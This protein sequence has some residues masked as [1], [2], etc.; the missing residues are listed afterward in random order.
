MKIIYT[1]GPYSGKD[2]LDI[3]QNIINAS[4]VAIECWR[5]GWAVICPHKNTSGYETFEGG[6]INWGTW[7]KGDLEIISRCD[8]IVMIQGWEKSKGAR[9]ELDF[10][11]KKGIRV[12]QSIDDVPTL[13]GKDLEI[14]YVIPF[15]EG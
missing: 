1:A 14:D 5:R 2:S 13:Y 3:Q 12:Y 15:L 8:A 9:M 7:L 11:N 4:R 6:N 10:A